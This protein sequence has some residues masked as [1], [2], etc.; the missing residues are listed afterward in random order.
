MNT[1][2]EMTDIILSCRNGKKWSWSSFWTKIVNRKIPKAKTL[3]EIYYKRERLDLK[4]KINNE[5]TI[6]QTCQQ[7]VVNPNIGIILVPK[8][9][10]RI[11]TTKNRMRKEVN[12]TRKTIR[13]FQKIA[14]SLDAPKKDKIAARKAVSHYLHTLDKKLQKA[15]K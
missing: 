12:T 9:E 6:R 2:E 3:S 11:I 15:L 13:Q 7:L 14:N 5:M 4:N 10:I 1:I 8:E